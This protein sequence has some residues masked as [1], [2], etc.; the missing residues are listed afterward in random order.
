MKLKHYNRYISVFFALFIALNTIAQQSTDDKLASM[1]LKNKE[2]EK[3]A[4]I[5][6]RLYN[7]KP[8]SYYYTYYLFCLI[9]IRDFKT[10]EKFILKE[11]KRNPNNPRYEVDLGYI[12][13]ENNE[14]EKAKKQFETA[15][16]DLR[17]DR[18]HI[19]SLANAFRS[20]RQNE[21][22]IKTYEKGRQLL[23]NSYSFHLELGDMYGYDQNHEKMVEEYL[24]MLEFDINYLDAVQNRLQNALNKDPDGRKHEILK[25]ELLKRIQRSPDKHFYSEMLL[26]LS[27]QEKDFELAL[28]QAKSLDRRLGEDGQRVFDLAKLC[29]SNK[30]YDVAAEAYSYLISRG[31]ENP[32]Y[33]GS[34]IEFLNVKYLIIT[35]SFDYNNEEILQLKNDYISTIDEFGRNAST[36]TLM[37]YLAHLQAFYLDE[38]DSAIVLLNETIEIPNAPPSL[39]AEC[40]LELADIFLFTGNVWDATLLY[41]QVEKAFKN[42]PIGHEA[43]LRNAKLSYFIGEFEWAKAQLDVLKAAT[44]KLIANDAMDLSLLISDNIDIDSST[45]AL[46]IYSRAELLEY[47][48]K[49]DLAL[50]T[51]DSIKNIAT[52]HP[53]SDEVLFKKAEIMIKKGMFRKAD[54]LLAELV[55]MYPYDI[56]GDD[57]LY[58]RAQLYELQ[59]KDIPIAMELYENIL[60]NYPGSLYASDARRNFRRLRGDDIEL[61]Q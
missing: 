51:L 55:E 31:E 24:E 4:S 37:R 25:N 45:T 38:A 1:F 22:A 39:K 44:S 60:L 5:Y 42:E 3:A 9:Q 10:A 6:E 36:I 27:I 14:S 17:A 57:A 47:R 28:I 18:N 56:L 21:W 50:A 23:N 13:L 54:T 20:R 48:N 43:K 46:S 29:I 2:Y 58:K 11:R 15:L 8:S 33:L 30:S 26:W 41:S 19:V 7:E 52:W 16:E 53:L 59:F 12:Y 32:Y 40:K 34:R 61:P 35:N 49:D